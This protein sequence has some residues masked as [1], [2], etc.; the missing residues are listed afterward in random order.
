MHSDRP[1]SYFDGKFYV[2]VPN[3]CN[4]RCDFCHVSPSFSNEARLN[5]STLDGVRQVFDN[6]K[7]LGFSEVKITGGEPLVFSNIDR[8]INAALTVGLRYSLLTNGINLGTFSSY[9]TKQPPTQLMVSVHSFKGN[10]SF[11]GVERNDTENLVS[12]LNDLAAAGVRVTVTSVVRDKSDAW[13][14]AEVHRALSSRIDC[15]VI[16]ATDVP[17]GVSVS[18]ADFESVVAEVQQSARQQRL[19]RVSDTRYQNCALRERG[20]L[21]IVLPSF[22]VSQCCAAANS[23][24]PDLDPRDIGQFRE[25]LSSFSRR[26]PLLLEN[27]ICGTD[28]GHCPLA[29]KT[30]ETDNKGELVTA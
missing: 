8:C 24:Q 9:L 30:L 29:L 5:E 15:K 23:A 4:A 20:F 18:E 1:T 19:V 14:I 25:I 26:R 7:R 22:R 16:R 21:S 3:L 11:F 2:F 27:A 28:S 10:S 13:G 6:A 17:S 12:R